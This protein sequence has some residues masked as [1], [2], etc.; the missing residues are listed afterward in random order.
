MMCYLDRTF[1]DQGD[2]CT[3]GPYRKLTDEHKDRAKA[4][5]IPVAMAN[6][7]GAKKKERA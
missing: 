2:A 4:L 3:C 1:C 6:F 7:C 5:G